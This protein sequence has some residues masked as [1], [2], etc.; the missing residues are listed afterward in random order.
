MSPVQWLWTMWGISIAVWLLC[1]F[2]ED[3]SQTFIMTIPGLIGFFGCWLGFTASS[4]LLVC[5]GLYKLVKLVIGI[6]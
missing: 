3:K 2:I 6:F 4:V 5:V 1:N